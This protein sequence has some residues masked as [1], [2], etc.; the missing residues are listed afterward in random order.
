M[1]S[2]IEGAPANGVASGDTK[3]TVQS[4]TLGTLTRAILLIS[5][6]FGILHFV[7]PIYGKEIGADAVQIGLFFSAFSLTAVLLRPIVGLAL[8]RYGRRPFFIAG[9]AGYA[10]TMFAFAFS[11]Q[12]WAIVVARLVQGIA[13]AFLWL[14]ADAI[15]ADVAPA[16]DRARFFGRVAQSSMQGALLGS[17]IGYGV[18]MTL[19]TDHGWTPLF[20]AYGAVS[21]LAALLAWRH[22]QETNPNGPQ[23]A[24]RPIVWSRAFVLLLM[25]TAV[26]AASWA[27]VSPILMVFLQERLAAE[28]RGLALA[29]IPAA[30]VWALLPS[31]L[32][33]LADRFGRKS[34]MVLGMAVAA[35]S[36]FLIPSVTSLAALAALWA[37]QAL[38]YAAGDPAEQALVA[39]LTGGD[40][41][42]RAYGIY[43]LAAGLGATVGPLLGGWLYEAVGARAPFYTN[44]A[45][46]AASTL[47][48]WALLEV[49]A[50]PA[51]SGLMESVENDI[52]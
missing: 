52:V 47:I 34:L 9:L 4:S 8:D 23:V 17:F 50:R 26:T 25:V 21:L 29:Y 32:G 13:S 36:S 24:R 12:V 10:L 37:L 16:N 41:R 44:G 27:M 39:D 19:D 1:T 43:A 5:L 22:L 11:A 46:L 45:I 3:C 7:L 38:C 28:I 49:P 40:Q 18:L 48:L 15:T 14:A 33:R 20:L 2:E 6:P 35:G 30:L 42:G 31:R 51:G